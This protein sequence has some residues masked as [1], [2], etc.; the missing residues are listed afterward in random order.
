MYIKYSHSKLEEKGKFT[1]CHWKIKLCDDSKLPVKANQLRYLWLFTL[2]IPN[3]Q[4]ACF[5]IF[6]DFTN[7]TFTASSSMLPLC[8][9]DERS[10]LLQFKESLIINETYTSYP[11]I[12]QPCRPKTESWKPEEVNIDCCTWMASSATKTRVMS[13][14][15]TSSVAASRVLSTLVAAFSSSSILSGLTLLLITSV[16]P[17]SHQK[18]STFQGYLI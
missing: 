4:F 10:A 7:A 2:M 12:N 6:I 8:H 16:P 15:L 17:K 18:S 9:D 13:S 5:L 1:H 3:L 14:S 11:W